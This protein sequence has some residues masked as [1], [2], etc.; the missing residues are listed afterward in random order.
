MNR[1]GLNVS[2]LA[3][4]LGYSTFTI[5]HWLR[6]REPRHLVK[7]AVLVALEQEKDFRFTPKEILAKLKNSKLT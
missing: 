2:D 1:L 5:Y 7:R 3:V 6:G 4:L